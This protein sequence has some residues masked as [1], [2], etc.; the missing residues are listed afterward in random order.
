[1]TDYI[2]AS[3]RQLVTQW[4]AGT[5]NLCHEIDHTIAVKHSGQR[6]SDNLVLACLPCNRHQG[7]DLT[8][9]DLLTGEIMPLFNPQTQAWSEHFSLKDGFI[10]GVTAVGQTT[11]FLL[12]VNEALRLQ[13]RQAL[14]LQGLYSNLPP[15]ILNEQLELLL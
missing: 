10:L 11:V 4:A 9:L 15:S 6:T 8:S 3:L 13:L 12:K 2:A 14:S 7:S 1:M 5:S